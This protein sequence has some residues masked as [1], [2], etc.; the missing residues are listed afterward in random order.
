MY[1]H[2]TAAM[3]SQLNE[4][5]RQL[6]EEKIR[7]EEKRAAELKRRLKKS[8]RRKADAL[9]AT[10]ELGGSATAVTPGAGTLEQGFAFWWS[11]LWFLVFCYPF[12]LFPLPRRSQFL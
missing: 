8:L 12:R 4:A 2:Q 5:H 7:K 11:G 3:G 10:A 1:A 6:N 9:K